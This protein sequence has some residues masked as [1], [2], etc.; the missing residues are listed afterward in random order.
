[1][2]DDLTAGAEAPKPDAAHVI[3]FGDLTARLMRGMARR[4]MLRDWQ[5]VHGHG[6]AGR[7]RPDGTFETVMRSE[8]QAKRKQRPFGM[9]GVRAE[10]R[11]SI[12][13]VPGTMWF[14]AE[15]IHGKP[16]V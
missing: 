3:R 11:R 6:S 10:D 9:R 13:A 7:R 14:K 5:R 12:Q 4:A 1:M 15:P 8:A 2:R 16:P